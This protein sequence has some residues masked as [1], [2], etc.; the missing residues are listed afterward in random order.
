MKS[1]KSN[2]LFWKKKIKLIHWKKIPKKVFSS[3]NNSF[4]WFSDGKLNVCYN[5]LDFHIEKGMGDKIAVHIVSQENKILSL[6]F[7]QLLKSVKKFIFLLEKIKFDKKKYIAIH[8]SSSLESVI[9]MLSCARLG[10]PHAVFF[11]ELEQ[12]SIISRLK[13]FKPDLLITRSNNLEF[14][15]KFSSLDRYKIFK[16]LKIISFSNNPI[17]SADYKINSKELISSKNL[18]LSDTIKYVNSNHKLFT[19]FTSGSTGIPKGI[20]HSSGGYLIYTKYTCIK[21]FG[22]QSKDVMFTASDAGWINGHTYA[23]YG[24]LS[25]GATTVL[26]EKPFKLIDLSLMQKILINCKVNILYLPVTLIRLVK[27]AYGNNKIKENFLKTLGSMGEPLSKF[28]ADWYQKFFLKK[29]KSIINTYFQTETGGIVYSPEHNDS[30]K[31]IENGSVGKSISKNIS[32]LKNKKSLFEIKINNSWPGC[33]IN[34]LN[35][36]KVYKKYWD[37]EKNFK[38]FDEGFI[39][40]KKNL[41]VSGRTDDVVNVRGHR[42][43][44]GE[45]ESILLKLNEIREACVVAKKDAIQGNKIY[46]FI[47]INKKKSEKKLNEKIN[48]LI[49]QNF[50]T[51]AIPEKILFVSNLPKTRSGKI[52]RRVLREIIEERK[53]D[54][55]SDTSTI[56]DK[57]IIKE[58]YDHINS[59]IYGN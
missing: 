54:D 11:E 34:V 43:G 47:T 39:S 14:K 10:I 53:I 37:N 4:K 6:T 29:R 55:L 58:I 45:I 59:K 49:H 57:S 26:I 56:L 9:A 20:E 30:K 41:F 3:S 8:A 12:K 7:K 5:C 42:I 36:L 2:N 23:L 52:L 50:G 33:M 46:I 13:L 18:K 28:I 38:M 16:K 15:N 25:V 32:I 21:K 35:G 17:K 40:K 1:T 27:V 22:L 31:S 19:L 51:F 44:S 48:K 24:P